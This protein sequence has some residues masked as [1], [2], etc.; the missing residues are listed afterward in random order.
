VIDISSF[1]FIL[2]VEKLK[3]QRYCN[4]YILTH[5]KRTRGNVEKHDRIT[6]S[7]P[8]PNFTSLARGYYIHTACTKCS[9]ETLAKVESNYEQDIDKIAAVEASFD[10][11]I[12]WEGKNQNEARQN[13]NSAL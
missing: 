8:I 12:V 1:S 7:R 11:V 10:T 2:D 6:I 4:S 13:S 3:H 5:F 9:Y